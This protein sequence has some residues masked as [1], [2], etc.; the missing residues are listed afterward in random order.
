MHI[1]YKI[2][3]VHPEEH[4]IVVRFYSDKMTEQM[5]AIEVQDG[6]IVRSRSDFALDLP[7]PAPTG[8]DLHNFIMSRCPVHFFDK[9]EKISDPGVDTSMSMILPLLG[10]EAVAQVDVPRAPDA[11]LV[12]D[13]AEPPESV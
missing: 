10:Q 6:K 12:V 3:E 8:T 1:K 9:H 11:P 4:Q 2:I 13:T 7:I 5:Q